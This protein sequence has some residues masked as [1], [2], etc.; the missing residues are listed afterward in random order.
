M[1]LGLLGGGRWEGVGGGE[2]RKR[3]QPGFLGK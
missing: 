1:Q 3:V 2:G